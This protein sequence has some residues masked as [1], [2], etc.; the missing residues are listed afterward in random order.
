MIQVHWE[1]HLPQSQRGVVFFYTQHELELQ[2]RDDCAC[3]SNVKFALLQ[4]EICILRPFTCAAQLN[5]KEQHHSDQKAKFP[6]YIFSS[7]FGCEKE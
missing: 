5:V 7:D 2:M 4:L 3:P 6:L 1:Q